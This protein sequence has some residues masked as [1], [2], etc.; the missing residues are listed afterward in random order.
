MGMILT[1]THAFALT[2]GNWEFQLLDS[3]VTITGYNGS[4]TDI[5]VPDTL[6][7]T[8]VTAVKSINLDKIDAVS[9]TFP[10]SVRSI[11]RIYNGKAL[12][13]IVLSDGLEE[14]GEYAFNG[15]KSLKNITLPSTLKA[16]NAQA[17]DSCSSLEQIDIPVG[18]EE[19]EHGAF[20]KCTAL[21][22]IDLSECANLKEIE[23][24]TFSGCTSLVSIK[25][26]VGIDTIP[27]SFCKECTSLV[28][29]EIPNTVTEIG[30]S[31][32]SNCSSLESIILPS[33]LKTL[34]DS[35]RYCDSLREVVIPY[36]TE[37]ILESFS[38]CD[39]L[40]A[41]Y[42][43]D[44]VTKLSWV[45]IYESDN[46]VIYC[47]AGSEAASVCAKNGISYLTDN[48]V[49]S[50]ITVLYNGK[51]VSFH[52]Y[53][54]NPEIVN[55]RTLVPLRA[56]F[57]AMNAEVEWDQ[58]TQTVTATRGNVTVKITIGDSKLYKNGEEIAVDVPAQ[59]INDRTMVPA[60]VI[61]EA[62]GANVEWNNNGRTVLITE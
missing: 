58:E 30:S 40:Q 14:I 22:T 50:L 3:E 37:T 62:F 31:A 53:N 36:G 52:A 41:L 45:V 19:I 59:L 2:E 10:S 24:D 5:V 6:A 17:F 61:A 49:N 35:F 56:I 20:Y 46:C 33:S 12:E 32:F 8:P 54:Q 48:S 43:P 57:E 29:V 7:G 16:I 28:N 55:D 51:R 27:N 4:D 11:G 18:I 23:R 21:K 13:T 15:C 42:I 1:M 47:T 25:F 34:Y 44:T 38:Y 9:I 26:P 60:R 39:N